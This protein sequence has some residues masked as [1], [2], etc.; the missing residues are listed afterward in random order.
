M[1]FFVILL[2]QALVFLPL[3]GFA[4]ESGRGSIIQDHKKTEVTAAQKAAVIKNYGKLPLYFIENK[5]QVDEK[6]SFYE[7]GAGH[8]TFFTKDGVVIGLTRRDKKAERSSRHDSI[9]K[10]LK[11]DKPAKTVSEAVSLSI[12][13]ANKG[14]KITADEKKSGHV[15]YFIGNDKKKWRTNIPTYGVVTY[16]EV[17]KNID[18][19]FY[20]NNRRLEHDVI[21]RPGGN[22]SNVKFAYKGIQ[23]LKITE[24]GDLEVFLK[25]GRLIEKKPVIYQEIGGKRVIVDGSYKLLGENDRGFEYGFN[26]ASYDHTKKIVIDPV[27]VYSTYLG[28]NATEDGSHIVL[29]STGAAYISGNTCSA[30]FPVVS[31]IQA[32]L[33][34]DAFITKINP[35]GSAL[36]YSTYLGG[37]L[38][39][40]FGVG[41]ALDSTDALYITGTTRASDFPMVNPIQGISGGNNEAFVTKLNPAGSALV[42]STY[43]GGSGHDNGFGI[44]VDAAGAAYVSGNTGSTNFPLVN[45]IQGVYG[46]AWDAFVTKINPAGS[47]FVYSTYLGGSDLDWGYGIALDP[48]GN[49]YVVGRTASPDFPLMNPIQGALGGA[50]GITDAFITKINPTGTAL[51]YSTYLGGSDSEFGNGIALDTSGNIY[52]TGYTNSLDFPT[53]TPFQ[54]NNA[55]GFDVYVTK[56]NPAG[57]AFIYSTYLGGSGD[58]KGLGLSLDVSD[59][60]YITGA[61]SSTDFPTASPVQGSSGGAQ[62][63]F[64]AMV[65]QAGSALTYSTYLGG[66]ALDW[67]SGIAVDAS[68][69]AYITGGTESTDFPTASPFQGVFAGVRDAIISKISG[70][71]PPPAVTLAIRADTATVAR[72][73]AIGYYVRATNTTAITQCFNYWENVT[74]PNSVIFPQNGE[75]FGP[76]HLCLSSGAVKTVHLSQAIPMIAPPGAYIYNTYLGTYPTPVM[77]SA[78]FNFNVTP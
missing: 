70:T 57:S 75:L 9:T 22:F 11:A 74:L 15:N 40:D 42:Y 41:I 28:G 25:D 63:G 60:I 20:G 3:A 19:K 17:Y 37:G 65:N 21:V 26:V 48:S 53:A 36:V 76:F 44:A 56:L 45:P 39:E 61:T 24:K 66:T 8:A 10:D 49:A 72:G 69:A 52:V 13:G 27:L 4:S 18:I 6:V 12:V 32:N 67:G 7:K 16:K 77:D 5:G 33:G 55:G 14:A 62:D 23:G 71:P 59:N 29:D 43:L 2:L 38:G 78:N 30:D 35:T 50:A 51:T 31:P 58:D 64:V 47:A 54:A 1:R 46:G 68:G 34:C 73:G